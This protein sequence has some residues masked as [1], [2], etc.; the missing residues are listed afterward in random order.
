MEKS[1]F[2][3]ASGGGVQ[4]LLSKKFPV[5]WKRIGIHDIAGSLTLFSGDPG[6][7]KSTMLLQMADLIASIEPIAMADAEPGSPMRESDAVLYITAEESVDQVRDPLIVSQS[8]VYCLDTSQACSVLLVLTSIVTSKSEDCRDTSEICFS[9]LQ[10]LSGLHF[11]RNC[12]LHQRLPGAN[13]CME[14]QMENRLETSKL[15]M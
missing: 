8:A 3:V 12:M 4:A 9:I 14:S 1:S 7:G 5:K 13:A 15:D 11:V 10:V 6:I 2:N